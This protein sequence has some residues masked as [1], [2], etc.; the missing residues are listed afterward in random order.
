MIP[1]RFLTSCRRSIGIA[2]RRRR[3][4]GILALLGVALVSTPGCSTWKT[5]DD[6]IIRV[7]APQS[8]GKAKRLTN[9]GIRALEN[10]D[11][12]TAAKRFIAAVAADSAYGPAHNNLGLMHYQAGNLF[13]AVLAFEEAMQ[14]M[15]HDPSVVYNLGLTL[16]AAGKT[17]E[18]E[19]LY[20]QAVEMDR[21]NPAYL[22]NLVRL[23]IRR[24]DRGPEVEQSLRD[25]ILI[26]TRQEWRSWA[27]EMLALRFN[28]AL[29]RGPPA[30]DFNTLS[31][32]E[33]DREQTPL[34]DRIIDLSDDGGPLDSLQ[35]TDPLGSTDR[36]S[37]R[38]RR[39]SSLPSS[40]RK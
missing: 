6:A 2:V 1:G 19:E 26:E 37:M 13:Q 7:T 35:L 14:W 5:A 28:A 30:P 4:F 3:R 17:I 31:D 38:I 20:A 9:A 27:D 32:E 34:D 21:A 24:G 25:L 8:P 29:D 18:A 12:D 39:R 10:G 40:R 23:R 33:R 36:S 11:D 22:G 15:P 16:E